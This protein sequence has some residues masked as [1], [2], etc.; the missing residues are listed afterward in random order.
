M[1][2]WR[3]HLVIAA[4]EPGDGAE[5]IASNEDRIEWNAAR[6]GQRAQQPLDG[7][8][9]IGEPDLDMLDAAG[10]AR[11]RDPLL[12]SCPDGECERLVEP[13]RQPC[14]SQASL[15]GLQPFADGRLRRIPSFRERDQIDLAAVE[16]V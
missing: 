5:L 3:A 15:D 4:C 16:P 14:S 11:L 13:A 1:R 12:L 8:G 2:F 9:F 7:I 10:D 6:A